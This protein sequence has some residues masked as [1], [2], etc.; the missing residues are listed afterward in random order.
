MFG[1]VGA[2]VED[3][4]ARTRHRQPQSSTSGVD[5]VE[6]AKNRVGLVAGGNDD[7]DMVDD[8][9]VRRHRT[10][11]TDVT[12]KI[13]RHHTLRSVSCTKTYRRRVSRSSDFQASSTDDVHTGCSRASVDERRTSPRVFVGRRDCHGVLVMTVSDEPM[14]FQ[15]QEWA[16]EDR[17]DDERLLAWDGRIAWHVGVPVTGTWSPAFDSTW[18]RRLGRAAY[19]A[20]RR[21]TPKP[22]RSHCSPTRER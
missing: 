22:A 1:G 2:I 19:R 17:F 4:D 12:T 9:P 21:C 14:L 20:S 16:D 15:G 5:G 18:S 7:C 10:R 11:H 6:R 3:D 8:S 13:R